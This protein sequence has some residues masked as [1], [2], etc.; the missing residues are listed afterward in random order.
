MS[1]SLEEVQLAKEQLDEENRMIKE[2]LEDYKSRS[3]QL[4]KD[5]D[6]LRAASSAK[7]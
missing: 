3:E 5:I 2:Q 6:D 4:S 7:E 1:R